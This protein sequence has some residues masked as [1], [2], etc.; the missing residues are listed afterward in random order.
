LGESD[1]LESTLGGDRDV[2]LESE[3][4]E[5]LDGMDPDFRR[6]SGFECDCV[7]L[8]GTAGES[9]AECWEDLPVT[10]VESW[11]ECW[12]DLLGTAEEGGA[13]I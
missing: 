12:E 4:A 3:V 11:A 6:S 10:A 5:D 7:D 9:W 8:L 13:G 2:D 1:F